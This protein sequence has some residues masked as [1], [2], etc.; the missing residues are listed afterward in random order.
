MEMRG[1]VQRKYQTIIYQASGPRLCV[2][3]EGEHGEWKAI[4]GSLQLRH[5][6]AIARLDISVIQK[7]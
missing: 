6:V 7:P 3:V 2:K 1:E 4:C 5:S